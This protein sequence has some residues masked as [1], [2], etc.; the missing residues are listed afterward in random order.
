MNTFTSLLGAVAIAVAFV[1]PI[2]ADADGNHGDSPR[3]TY[4]ITDLGSLGGTESFAY[5]INDAGQVVGYSRI[6]G[7]A[8][9]ESFLYTNG[10]MISLSPLNSEDIL[11]VGPTSINNR[12]QVASGIISQGTYYP[13]IYDICTDEVAVLG[14]L[15]GVTSYDFSGVSTSINELRQSVG[16]SYLDASNR[17]AFLHNEGLMTDIGT[18]GGREDYSS[19]TAI[20][21]DGMIVGFSSNQLGGQLTHLYMPTA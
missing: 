21:D 2:C 4:R 18:L 12:G 19:A 13:A 15:G 3:S 7:D 14:S 8:G 20:N 17:H 5:A 10:E 9:G 6:T 16:Y 11:T 1:A